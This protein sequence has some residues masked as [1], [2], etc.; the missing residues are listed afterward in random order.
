VTYNGKCY[1]VPLLVTRFIQN[2]IPP[3]V[4]SY[5]HLDLLHVARRLWRPRLGSCSLADVESAILGVAREGDISGARIPEIYFRYV[6]GGDPKTLVPVFHHNE[7]DIVSLVQ[8]AAEASRLYAAPP[9]ADDVHPVDLYSLARSLEIDGE[10]ETARE[11]LEEA[12]YADL[13]PDLRRAVLRK[14]SLI[15]KQSE[16]WNEAV[17][18][19]RELGEL[20]GVY[21]VFAFEETAKYFE[22][23]EKAPEIALE[24]V[25]RI[26]IALEKRE[27]V[28]L[29]HY[30]NSDTAREALEHRLARLRKKCGG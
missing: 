7:L 3:L 14:L 21:D 6:R 15:H 19:W 24:V 29:A 11:V 10:S 8:L 27:P 2:R 16:R 30:G 26:V 25:R 23:R 13:E 22:H 5:A 20:D 17:E 12:R 18:L 9:K 28:C 4:E 1:D